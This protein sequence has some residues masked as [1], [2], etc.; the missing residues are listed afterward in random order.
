MTEIMILEGVSALRRE[1]RRYLTLGIFVKAPREV[2]L[3]RGLTRDAA[4]GTAE[5]ITR[6]WDKWYREEEGY[7]QRD[8]PERHADLVLDGTQPFEG[9]ID[10]AV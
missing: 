6:N 4:M 5:E 3:R 1:F 10:T 8:D 2:C 7:L 9:Q